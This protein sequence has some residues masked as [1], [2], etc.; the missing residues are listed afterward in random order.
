VFR[1][2]PSF[3]LYDQSFYFSF[4]TAVVTYMLHVHQFNPSLNDWIGCDRSPFQG[5]FMADGWKFLGKKKNRD[6][7][8]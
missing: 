4:R 5:T 6:D 7:S 1:R 3:K 2:L 8:Q